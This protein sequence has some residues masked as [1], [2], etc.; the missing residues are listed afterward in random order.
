MQRYAQKWIHRS[1][2]MA[3]SAAGATTATAAK[4]NMLKL[5]QQG[6]VGIIQLHRPDALN[7]LCND[8]F[9]ELNAAL[10]AYDQNPTIGAI[11]ITGDEKAF[12]GM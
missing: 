12:A 8:L 11:V 1:Y 6:K 2:S 10:S 4:P 7:A 3:T 5:R 9:T